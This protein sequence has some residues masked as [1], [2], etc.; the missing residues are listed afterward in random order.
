[1]VS[2]S[3]H[4]TS[5]C[6]IGGQSNRAGGE[7]AKA[8]WDR[9]SWRFPN[10][11]MK[12]AILWSRRQSFGQKGQQLTGFQNVLLPFKCQGH[13]LLMWPEMTWNRW[14]NRRSKGDQKLATGRA[15]LQLD[16]GEGHRE[17]QA[18]PG[19]G[20]RGLRRSRRAT[21]LPAHSWLVTV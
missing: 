8:S 5:L 21:Q 1:M 19:R 13:A 6:F 2:K 7:V 15:L 11:Q 4:T 20:G 10:T 9:R 18:C 17:T 14:H 12:G 16:Q 3:S